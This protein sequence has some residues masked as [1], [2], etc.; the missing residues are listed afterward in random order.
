[1]KKGISIRIMM[2]KTLNQKKSNHAETRDKSLNKN[3]KGYYTSQDKGGTKNRNRALIRGDS[4]VKN[5][6]G[7]RPSKRIK[8]TVF[9][10]ID[11]WCNNEGYE[12]SCE[13]FERP[14]PC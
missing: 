1:M 6:E 13:M 5:V 2:S 3:Y 10:K 11:S 14:F 7:W 4:I 9:C 8:S 12:T